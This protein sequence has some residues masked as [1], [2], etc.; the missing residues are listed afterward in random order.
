MHVVLWLV[1]IPVH[2]LLEMWDINGTRITLNRH[3]C[4]LLQ[5]IPQVHKVHCSGPIFTT[6]L[7]LLN[8]IY[9]SNTPLD[10]T[11][12]FKIAFLLYKENK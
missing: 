5:T 1:S 9:I 2:L 12:Q 6:M 11:C 10:E 8:S 4:N 7:H 3:F